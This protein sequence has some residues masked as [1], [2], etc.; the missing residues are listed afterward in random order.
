MYNSINKNI[1]THFSL[2][3]VILSFILL[4]N[5][6]LHAQQTYQES[7]GL[8]IIEA[9][10]TPSDYD[11]WTDLTSVSGFT[12]SS[13]LE[14]TGNTVINGN[15][16]SPLEYHFTINQSGLYYLHLHCAREN[17]EINGELRTDVA[18]DCYVRVEGD[19]GAGPNAGNTH[20]D[21]APLALLTSDTKFFGG[22]P[23]S[24]VWASGNRLDPGGHQNKRIAIYDFKAG[25]TYK[26]FV[27]GR[28]QLFKLNRIVFRHQ[29]VTN[30]TAQNLSTPESSTSEPNGDPDN[31]NIPTEVEGNEDPDNDGIPN[32]LDEDSD[33]DNILDI[34]EGTEDSDND[35]IPNYLDEDSDNDG[36]LDKHEASLGIDPYSAYER[37]KI[38]IHTLDSENIELC[39]PSQPTNQFRLWYSDDLK[40]DSW[41]LYPNIIDADN[42]DETEIPL[43]L[44][45]SKRFFRVELYEGQSDLGVTFNASSYNAES[46]PNDENTIRNEGNIGFIRDNSWVRYDNFDFNSG[47]TNIIVSAA[48]QQNGGTIAFR[49]GSETGQIIG[50]VNVTTTSQWDNYQIFSASLTSSVSGI[51]DLYLVFSGSTTYL[52]NIESF[53]IQE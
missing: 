19:Y 29:S 1:L 12:G 28:S 18:N 2:L 36:D 44:E 40:S 4:S 20:G 7:D 30:G 47:A 9:E 22:N 38:D 6:S 42:S 25:E 43:E 52:Y 11:K 23:N 53:T 51:H 34:N 41:K 21:D 48:S 39:W 17:V 50:T 14:F 13:Y 5:L 10:N 35:G 27:S 24:F 33:G 49:L 46:H 45:I 37:F 32:Y 26:L 31:D 15:P 8:V 3:G 16:N